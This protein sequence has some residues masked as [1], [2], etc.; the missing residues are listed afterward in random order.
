[1]ASAIVEVDTFT[2]TI[3]VPDDG[4]T[5]SAASVVLPVQGLSNRT[6]WLEN[7]LL[8]AGGTTRILDPNATFFTNYVF[9]TTGGILAQW[10]GQVGRG[11]M[12]IPIPYQPGAGIVSVTL[13]HFP[14]AG[15]FAGAGTLTQMQLHSQTISTGVAAAVD[16]QIDPAGGAG[17]YDALHAFTLTCAAT[18]D[19]TTDV[20]YF[21]R[22]LED[23]GGIA[24][25]QITGITYVSEPS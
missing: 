5:A 22:I 21:L 3:T 23:D 25:G 9:T 16:T 14:Q 8:A 6:N 15:S 18:R 20:H 13:T 11:D 19:M 4:D 1:M 10:T 2:A 7:R 17:A 12:Y 24:A